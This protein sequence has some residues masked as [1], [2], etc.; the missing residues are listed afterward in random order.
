MASA[1]VARPGSRHRGARRSRAAGRGRPARAWCSRRATG[2]ADA[3]TPWT[4]PSS[5]SPIELGAE[6]VHGRPAELVELI[7][8]SGLTLETVPE[9]ASG[10]RVWSRAA[11]RAAA[12][13]GHPRLAG[14]AARGR[15]RR[16]RSPGGRPHP[17]ARGVAG[18]A[19][20]SS[21]ARESSIS[22]GSTPPISSLL[23][24]PG[25]GRER[26]GGGRRRRLACTGSAKATARSSGGWPTDGTTRAWRS[27]SARW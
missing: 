13:A 20:A 6:F 5:P 2:S 25:T 9:V 11:R 14:N 7:R 19:R 12:H 18:A 24:H 15:S 22:R 4:I 10:C 3:S 17:R 21:Q 8:E 27:G 16:P 1:D 26:I 23:G